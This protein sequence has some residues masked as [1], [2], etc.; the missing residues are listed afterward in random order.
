MI[1]NLWPI[2]A[3]N[4]SVL[5]AGQLFED[6]AQK[7]D[8]G[9]VTKRVKRDI[10]RVFN[11]SGYVSKDISMVKNCE[12]LI[13]KL[14]TNDEKPKCSGPN[15]DEV[16][17]LS[18]EFKRLESHLQGLKWDFIKTLFEASIIKMGNNLE[19]NINENNTE[20]KS[21]IQIIFIVQLSSGGYSQGR[22]ALEV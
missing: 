15:F 6:K 21:K 22:S 8:L 16:V 11:M 20:K 17:F 10:S 4:D 5:D 3:K 9:P 2:Q 7:T 13:S 19:D 12:Y 18:P 14:D 1:T